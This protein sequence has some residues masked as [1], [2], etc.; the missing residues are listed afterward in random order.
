MRSNYPKVI[1]FSGIDGAGKS[2]Q[3]QALQTHLKELGFH[4]TLY[5]FWDNVV[6][7]PGLRERMSLRAFK[8]DKGVG[9]PDNP[10]TRRDKNVSSWYIIA[11]RLFL[12]LL[13]AYSLRVAVS[14]GSYSGS[15]FIIFDRYIY[16]EL[17]NL[18]LH[19]PTIELYV[20]LLLRLTPKPNVAYIV[21]ADPQAAHLRKP[22]YPLEFVHANRNAYI[23][24]SRLVRSIT[25][26]AP[27][28]VEQTASRIKESISK[29]C[30]KMDFERS[31]LSMQY[32]APSPQAKTPNA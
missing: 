24:L 25:V 11:I 28:S 21:D 1:S 7:F 6:V 22:E 8:G 18:P 5:T 29:K 4:S 30:L 14:G 20:S 17:A 19:R 32:P 3:I 10:I 12:Y 15:D 31:D 16:D 2:T 26:L 27:T 23:A 9:S 13:D